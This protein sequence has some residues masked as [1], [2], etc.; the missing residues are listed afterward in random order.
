MKYISGKLGKQ[1]IRSV[2]TSTSHGRQGSYSR[3]FNKDGRELMTPDELSN[4]DNINCIVFI[5][6]LLPF[7]SKKYDLE[8]HPN[9]KLT[10]DANDKYKF[11]V[12]EMLHTGF[13]IGEKQE[14]KRAIRLIEEAQ[15]A[16]TRITERENRHYHRPPRER[17]AGGKECLR[18]EPISDLFPHMDIPLNNLTPEQIREQT[19]ALQNHTLEEVFIPPKE[20][21]EED[22]K[23]ELGDIDYD[24]LQMQ[25]AAEFYGPDEESVG[26]KRH[27]EQ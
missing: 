17:T 15:I 22:Y 20:V 7:F 26:E 1:T 14:R 18:S 21:Y 10:G 3:S 6:G 16:D 13:N 2:N 23:H 4:M 19:E 11:N 27:A 8:A 12:K 25:L 24:M 9:Y 5:R